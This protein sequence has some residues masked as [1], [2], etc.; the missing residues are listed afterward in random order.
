MRGSNPR[1][2]SIAISESW[3]QETGGKPPE[4]RRRFSFL[5]CVPGQEF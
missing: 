4:N 2:V 3:G 5:E 1:P